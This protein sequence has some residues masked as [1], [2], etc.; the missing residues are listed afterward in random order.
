MVFSIRAVD[1]FVGFGSLLESLARHCMNL[2]VVPE[3]GKKSIIPNKF[4]DQSLYVGAGTL[5][6]LCAFHF[7][8]S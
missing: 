8:Y 4:F 1:V 7:F 5:G 6:V 3:D 2:R